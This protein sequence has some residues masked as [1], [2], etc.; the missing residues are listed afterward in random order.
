MAEFNMDFDFED[1]EPR[2]FN[3]MHNKIAKANAKARKFGKRTLTPALLNAK[4]NLPLSSLGKKSDGTGFTT[5]DLVDFKRVKEYLGKKFNKSERGITYAQIVANSTKKDLDRSN[6]RV[7]D[8]TGVKNASPVG[9]IGDIF[10]VNVQSSDASTTGGAYRVQIRFESWFDRMSDSEGT[11]K[12][13]EKTIRKIISDNL[14]FECNCGQHQ[15]TYRYLATAGNFALSP[16]EYAFPK[17]R[18][19]HG[20][21]VACK[22]VLLALNKLK[23][24]SWIKL[25]AKTMAKAAAKVGYGDKNKFY[26]EKDEIKKANSLSRR[27]A[28]DS[29]REKKA[30]EKHLRNKVRLANRIKKDAN[31]LQTLQ[32]QLKRARA[33]NQK[34]KDKKIS[35][36]YKSFSEGAK[37]FGASNEDILSRFAEKQ[38]LSKANLNRLKGKLKG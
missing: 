19:P 13:D 8:G 24:V 5:A 15:Y 3:A 27:G 23:S 25:I 17:I 32:T 31:K 22:H 2:K 29:E 14:S 21:G 35:D 34:L 12:G 18:N 28:L 11:V 37:A 9:V 10:T 6:N 16:K 30:F 26:F 1:I 20:E 36:S 4:S 7:N 38:K 33:Q